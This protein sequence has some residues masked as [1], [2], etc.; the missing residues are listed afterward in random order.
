MSAYILLDSMSRDRA[1]YPSQANFTV[2]ADQS[3]SWSNLIK[4][5]SCVRP[6][7]RKEVCNLLFSVKLNFLALPAGT[8]N[9][10][11]AALPGGEPYIFVTFS[12]TRNRTTGA[13][14][15]MNGIHRS[16]VFACNF[17]RNYGAGNEWMLY[18]SGQ[19]QTIK[20]DSYKPEIIFRVFTREGAPAIPL[21][22]PQDSTVI[23]PADNPLPA[24]I[25]PAVQIAAEFELT[26]YV[27]DGDFDNH[28]VTLSSAR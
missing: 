5:V 13:I 3:A 15:M 26:P 20:L 19:T 8:T 16:A 28:V 14:K 9:A 27:R 1:V 10:S 4:E 6:C 7:G 17:I 12:D 23:P 11:G 22:G 18:T 21:V 24:N 2:S 25:N